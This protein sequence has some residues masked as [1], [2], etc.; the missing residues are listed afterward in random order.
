MIGLTPNRVYPIRVIRRASAAGM[1]GSSQHQ[2][3]HMIDSQTLH[4]PRARD[5]IDSRRSLYKSVNAYSDDVWH[6]VW[7]RI[8]NADSA[9]ESALQR[10][11]RQLLPPRDY[12]SDNEV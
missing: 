1:L 11:T 5:G 10:R 12:V 7:K 8:E 4:A 2:Y 3:E 9:R 6:S